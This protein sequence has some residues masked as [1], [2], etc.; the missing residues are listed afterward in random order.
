MKT[1]MEERLK[2]LLSA[3]AHSRGYP[4]I[5]RAALWEERLAM[6][7]KDMQTMLEAPDKYQL[8]VQRFLR[9]FRNGYS[10]PH[11]KFA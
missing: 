10:P 4:F 1:P 6:H 7:L 8:E 3:S 9:Q 11:G 5:E 2:D